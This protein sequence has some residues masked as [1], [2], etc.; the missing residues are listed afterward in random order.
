MEFTKWWEDPNLIHKQLAGVFEGG[1]AKGLAYSGALQALHQRH[2]WFDAV[3]GASAG[4]ITA[5]LI[6]AGLTPMQITDYSDKLLLE[7]KPKTGIG[8]FWRLRAGKGYYKKEVIRAALQSVLEPLRDGNDEITFARLY[9]ITGIEL[10]IVCADISTNLIVVFN[11]I[12]TPKCQVIDTALASSSIPFAFRSSMLGALDDSPGDEEL[13]D[14]EKVDHH[15]WH[16]TIV[17]GGVSSNFPLFVFQ[18][19]AFRKYMHHPNPEPRAD[20]IGFVLKK[21]SDAT[22]S[23]YDVYKNSEFNDYPYKGLFYKGVEKM[24]N[25]KSKDDPSPTKR[26]AL[27]KILDFILTVVFGTT[28]MI[29]A[30]HLRRKHSPDALR[31]KETETRW[32]NYYV[33]SLSGTLGFLHAPF[34]FILLTLGIV[35]GSRMVL[36]QISLEPP[37]GPDVDAMDYLSQFVYGP[38]IALSFVV[39]LFIVWTLFLANMF[40][41]I[42]TRRLLYGLARTYVKGAFAV[43]WVA[44]MDNVI[45]LPIP[46]ELSVLN[47]NPGPEL[48]SK[49]ID[50]ARTATLNKL[51]TLYPEMPGAP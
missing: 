36:E 18:D 35:I 12:T 11:H 1:G 48:K 44:L 27:R 25:K 2:I 41:L 4:A 19:R 29:T 40:T 50:A 43:P 45:C 15:F 51:D 16:R 23:L 8:G 34:F 17:D 7:I 10:N 20:V 30:V 32:V 28:R 47:F 49:T 24:K 38:L 5:L 33:K 46:D 9:A 3:A 39:L 14:K 42:P 31:W 37:S 13:T 26:S 22:A 21:E 6:A